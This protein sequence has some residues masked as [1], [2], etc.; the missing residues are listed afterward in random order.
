MKNLEEVKIFLNGTRMLD[1][2]KQEMKSALKGKN[3]IS[4]LAIQI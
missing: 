2:S 1:S 3:K 4:K